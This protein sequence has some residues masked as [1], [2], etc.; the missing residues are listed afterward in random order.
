MGVDGSPLDVHGQ[1]HVTVVAQGNTLETQ[2]LV[3][4]LLTTE[5][6]LGLDVLKKHQATIDVRN[7]QLR[8]GSCNCTLSLVEARTP[9]TP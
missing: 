5:G 2:A 8:F 6:I 3:V 4:S 7:R 1:V 9:P